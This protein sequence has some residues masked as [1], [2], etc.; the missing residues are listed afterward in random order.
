M[1]LIE[2]RNRVLTCVQRHRNSMADQ[3]Y[4]TR[5]VEALLWLAHREEWTGI[6]TR[7]D[8]MSLLV[9]CNALVSSRWAMLSGFQMD[10]TMPHGFSVHAT[11]VDPP[12]L[13][14]IVERLENSVAIA[15]S[16]KEART[17]SVSANPRSAFCQALDQKKLASRQGV[18]RSGST[19]LAELP[20]GADDKRQILS[21]HRRS[22]EP[23]F[24][25][26]DVA[27]TRLIRLA[28]GN[29]WWRPEL[30]LPPR[31]RQVLAA[32]ERGLSEKQCANELNLS[33]H[34]IHQHVKSLYRRFQVCSRSELLVSRFAAQPS[35]LVPSLSANP[36]ISSGS[37]Y[38]LPIPARRYRGA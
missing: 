26:G 16:K 32:L 36:R 1:T 11:Q 20:V 19:V 17:E 8:T 35:L 5:Q 29:S 31:L 34:T 37:R 18:W 4:S 7:T 15:L 13:P 22:V 30:Q 12:S 25:I 23:P 2:W 10:E 24:T 6:G 9:H 38:R 27:T 33:R 14:V 28:C 3:Q 21:F